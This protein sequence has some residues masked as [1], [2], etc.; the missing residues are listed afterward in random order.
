VASHILVLRKSCLCF[1]N[2]NWTSQKDHVNADGLFS[3]FELCEIGYSKFSGETREEKR[4]NFPA[5][6]LRILT[7]ETTKLNTVNWWW[8]LFSGVADEVWHIAFVFRAWQRTA[9][10]HW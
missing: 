8:S 6:Y 4:V 9:M 10:A 3:K 7:G 5:S 1:S 2:S